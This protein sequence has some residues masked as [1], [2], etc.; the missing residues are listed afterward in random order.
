MFDVGPRG[1][2]GGGG[3]YSRGPMSDQQLMKHVIETHDFKQLLRTT[4]MP[5]RTFATSRPRRI[6]NTTSR[7]RVMKDAVSATKGLVLSSP[8][9]DLV[10]NGTLKNNEGLPAMQGYTLEGSCIEANHG[11][12]SGLWFGAQPGSNPACGIGASP[13]MDF[14]TA[15]KIANAVMSNTGRMHALSTMQGL[16][17]GTWRRRYRYVRPGGTVSRGVRG[18][19]G[20]V[21]IN[22]PT[23]SVERKASSSVRSRRGVNLAFYKTPAIQMEASPDRDG[24]IRLGKPEKVIH[25]NV[26]TKREKKTAKK[27]GALLGAYHKLTEIND[28]IDALADAIPGNPCGRMPGFSKLVCVVNNFESIDPAQAAF[29]VAYNELED[30]LVGRAQGKL[31]EALRKARV[32]V[33]HGP[34]STQ[35]QEFA[36]HLKRAKIHRSGGLDPYL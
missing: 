35:I 27:V 13:R 24:N 9:V 16:T 1:S 3:S 8:D 11:P 5:D 6:P 34:N 18:L 12:L 25:R 23:V 19:L 33:G 31:Q 10:P 30:R 4:K 22:Q 20:A 17:A 15:L 26:R 7:S 29:N 2:G 32:R 28:L 21:E 36:R 14:G